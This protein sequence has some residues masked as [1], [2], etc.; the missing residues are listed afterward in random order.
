MPLQR[1]WET[2]RIDLTTPGEWIEVK[3][4]L[5]KDDE[6]RRTALLL[7]GQRIRAGE[8]LTEFDAAAMFD[9]AVFA[10]IEVAA[11]AWSVR[12]PETNKV[13]ELTPANIRALSDEDIA[14]ISRKLEEMY[15]PPLS[16]DEAK[17]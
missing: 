13:A 16:E 17:N 1:T 7:R 3:T 10:T 4:K 15:T 12:D 5:G 8:S 6:R 14:I 9:A 2:V 11:Q